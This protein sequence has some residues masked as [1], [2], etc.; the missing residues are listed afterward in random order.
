M[1]D[2]ALDDREFKLTITHYMNENQ[3]ERTK[4]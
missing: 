4:N 2:F 1:S 3:E